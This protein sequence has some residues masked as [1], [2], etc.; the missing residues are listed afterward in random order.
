MTGLPSPPEIRREEVWSGRTWDRVPLPGHA[1][2]LPA[3]PPPADWQRYVNAVRRHRWSVLAITLLGTA[4]GA[5]A[6]RFL[7]PQYAA[8]A[9][10]WIEASGREQDRGLISSEELV[11]ASGWVELVTSNAVLDSVVRRLDL[12]LRLRTP[13]DSAAFR[14]LALSETPRAGRYR[15]VV[16]RSG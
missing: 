1:G 16:A 15:L 4:A 3:P 7:E 2:G 14:S 5:A 10:L 13:E 9:M 12:F 11:K 6:T 8:T